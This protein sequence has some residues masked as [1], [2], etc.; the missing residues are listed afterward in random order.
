[1]KDAGQQDLEYKYLNDVAI[2]AV[3]LLIGRLRD[4]KNTARQASSAER[5]HV[6]RSTTPHGEASG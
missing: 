1:V 3:D 6:P 5:W 2:G 4:P